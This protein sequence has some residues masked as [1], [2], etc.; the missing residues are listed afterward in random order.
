VVRRVS[1]S[2]APQAA[3]SL[4]IDKWL[5][6]ARIV[7]TRVLA[8]EL[9]RSGHVRVNGQRIKDASKLVRIGDVLTVALP[10]RVRVL[11]VTDVAERRGQAAEG[12]ALYEELTG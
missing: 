1:G 7:K 5:W 10:S 2:D 8:Q 4:R 12:A 9:A 6:F 11:K 3:V